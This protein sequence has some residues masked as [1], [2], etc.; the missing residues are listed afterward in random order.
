MCSVDMGGGRCVVSTSL[1]CIE[2]TQDVL[3]TSPAQIKISS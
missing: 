1:V 3:T 2:Y